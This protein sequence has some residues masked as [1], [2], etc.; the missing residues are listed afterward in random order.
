M[1]LTPDQRLRIF[2]SS[3]LDLSDERAAARRSIERL[4]LTPVMFEAGARPHPPR[5][6]YR[7][8]V[9]HSDVFVAIYSRRYGW[10]APGMDLSGLED[11]FNL[12]AG[13]PR[14][15]YIQANVEREPQLRAFLQ[16][17]RDGGSVVQALQ[18]GRR[19]G[20]TAA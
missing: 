1:I 17:V 16:R 20:G 4:D 10:T 7:A 6:L 18:V 8:Y 13:K 5:A 9:E 15:V 2:I 12:S 14:L 3:T 11:E 19:P